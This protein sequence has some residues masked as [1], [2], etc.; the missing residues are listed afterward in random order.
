[1]NYELWKEG[2]EVEHDA[3]VTRSEAFWLERRHTDGRDMERR[4]S[5]KTLE[6]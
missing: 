6:R 5:V 1:M 4:L 2:I 3:R